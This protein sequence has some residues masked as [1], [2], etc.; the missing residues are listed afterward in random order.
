MKIKSKPNAT[1]RPAFTPALVAFLATVMALPMHA[2]VEVP[3]VPPGSGNGVPPNILF[4]LDDSGSMAPNG[5]QFMDRLGFSISGLGEVD[6]RDGSRNSYDEDDDF[7]IDDGDDGD[8]KRD[9]NFFSYTNN[10]LYYNPTTTYLP[11]RNGDGSF[12]A[13]TPYTSAWE[14]LNLARTAVDLSKKDRAFHVPKSDV[15][16]GP[17]SVDETQAVNYYRYRFK[18]GGGGADRCDWVND[19]S[20]NWSWASSNCVAVSTFTWT[21][22]QE[23]GT[24][25]TIT[26]SLAQEKANFANWFSFHRTRM[27][28][29][30][31]GAGYAFSG[32]DGDN[33]RVG[34]NSIW[35]NSPLPIP[36]GNDNGLFKGENRT[37]WF[38]ALYDARGSGT[39]PLRT[40][41]ERAGNY[42]MDSSA[43]GPY[44]GVRDADGNQF[45]CR[46]NFAILTTDGFWNNDS[47]SAGNADNEPGELIQAP[48]LPS[49][50][51]GRTYQYQPGAPYSGSNSG[52]LADVAMKY[53]KTDLR[54]AGN[55]PL[56]NI[57]PASAA[58]PAFWQHMVTFGISIGLRGTLPYTSV[59]EVWEA[60]A[61][62]WPNPIDGP[63]LGDEHRIDDLLH[64]AVNGHGEFVAASDPNAFAK[65]LE[66]ALGAVSDRTGSASNVAASSTSISTD[67]RLFQA[68]YLGGDWTGE[69]TAY[70]VTADGINVASPVWAAS[71]EFPAWDSRDI[72]TTDS[73]GA[74]GLFPTAKQASDLG[75]SGPEDNPTKF[76]IAEY[77]QGN[78]VGELKNG[79]TLRS[80]TSLLGD[81]IHSSPHYVKDSD[82]L[83]VGA[84][85]GMLHAFDGADGKEV[86]AYVP[87][88]VSMA[89]LK[90][91]SSPDYGHHYYV[92]GPVVVSDRGLTVTTSYPQGRNILVGTL[93]HGGKGVFGLD[94]TDPD[95]FGTGD[96]LFDIAGDGDMGLVLGKPFVARLNDGSVSVIFGNGI[97][98]ANESAV[99]WIVNVDTGAMTKL[100]TGATGNNGLS[101][102]RGWDSDGDGT[103]DLVYA[104]DQLGNLWKFDLSGDNSTG[105][106]LWDVGL[107][108]NPLFIATDAAGKRQPISGGV[109]IGIDPDKYKRW[110]FFGTG[111]LLNDDDLRNADGTPN[112]DVQTMYGIIDDDAA[113]GT[114][115]ANDDQSQ[116]DGLVERSIKATGSIDGKPVRSFESSNATMPAGKQGW[117]ID[118]LTPPND[119]PEGERIVGNPQVVGP[120]LI[121]SSIIPSSDPCIPGGRG[122]INALNA[123]TGASVGTHF[124]DVDGD[125]A[126]SD[127]SLGGDPVGSVD[128]GVGMNTDGVLIDKLIGVGG[129]S[130]TTGSVGVNN[131]ASSGRISWREILGD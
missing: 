15:F 59:G 89:R 21:V 84:N 46:Q 123:F 108:G 98:S 99:L 44:G 88:G 49:G 10:T 24:T 120:V 64:A 27:K 54:G 7:K 124:F 47:T 113:I 11:W 131:P 34:Y 18:A 128:T 87:R 110:L 66:A 16:N 90:E 69:I 30:K 51:P 119:T 111:R 77:I 37:R 42:F 105:S 82:T 80:R 85:D 74:K 63:T 118:L 96:I 127:D 71:E 62:T 101:A 73:N 125:G 52:T 106:A 104:G 102:P 116:N 75:T 60:G 58:D 9:I 94:V 107:N 17:G 4:I 114:R 25:K 100:D 53:W 29:A 28:A 22:P 109:S 20:G 112:L 38:E 55:G 5:G 2:A 79:G 33:Y 50:D 78:D 95:S 86:F 32:L 6:E 26:R 39:T 92:D 130:G 91:L 35:N 43:A 12:V 1:P 8:N 41:L 72:Y 61:F 97:N 70:R 115:A 19:G 65:G 117:F 56:D 126:Y 129:S 81:I 83:Y 67:T 122:Y 40:A 93:G 13:A 103:V 121:T 57:V 31:A 76:K 68:K 36:V 14:D 45:A 23:D 3:S 48:D